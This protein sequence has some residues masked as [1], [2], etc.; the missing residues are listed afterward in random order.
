MPHGQSPT[1]KS[2]RPLASIG[3]LGNA[4][5]ACGI[6]GSD[7]GD[8][9]GGDEG[10]ERREA[11]GDEG[12]EGGA[13]PW[14]DSATSQVGVPNGRLGRNRDAMKSITVLRMQAP[15]LD[16]G[17]QGGLRASGGVA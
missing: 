14:A 9:A 6:R 1:R 7:T 4:C 3:H 10:G 13:V 8:D 2:C 15:E 12:G 11:G 16:G 17:L 5:I